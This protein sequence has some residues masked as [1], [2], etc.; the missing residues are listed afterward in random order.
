MFL[1]S[2]D[3]HWTLFPGQWI[4]AV[5][6]SLIS[7]SKDVEIIQRLWYPSGASAYRRQ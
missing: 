5:L 7:N 4:A 1:P 3:V 2:L 6:F